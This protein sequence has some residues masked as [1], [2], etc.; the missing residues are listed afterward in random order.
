MVL[1]TN[2][3]ILCIVCEA[4]TDILLLFEIQTEQYTIYEVDYVCVCVCKGFEFVCGG[5]LRLFSG[6]L[7]SNNEGR[8]VTFWDPGLVTMCGC[9]VWTDP[10]LVSVKKNAIYIYI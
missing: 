6:H 7:N 2:L 9:G 10:L 1:D 3:V 4:L 8:I 5:W